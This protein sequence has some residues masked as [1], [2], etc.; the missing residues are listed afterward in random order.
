MVTIDPPPAA[1][2]SGS[3]ARAQATSE[4]AL[5]SSASQNRSRGVSVKRPSRSSAAA[6][7]TEWTSRSRCP[8][9]AFPTSAKTRSTSSSERT[10]H[11]VT[12]GLDTLPASSRTEGSIRSPWKVNASSAPSSA[13]LRAMP[14]AI[15]RLLATPKPRP[16][17]PSNLPTAR[18][19]NR[20]GYPSPLAPRDRFLRPRGGASRRGSDGSGPPADQALVR[21][22]DAAAP[23][24][25]HHPHPCRPRERPG[26]RDRDAEAAAARRRIR[27][28]NARLSVIHPAPRRPDGVLPRLPGARLHGATSRDGGAAPGDPGSEDWPPF[29]DRPR[30]ADGQ[31]PGEAPAGARQARLR[32]EGLPERPLHA[33]HRPAPRGHRRRRAA[34]GDGRARRRD[35]DRRG[36][37]R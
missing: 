17:L 15:E 14:H 13:S 21:R 30:R 9:N 36:R 16:R 37:R 11:A 2:I 29:S 4:Y 25:R 1:S 27:L 33:P 26:S 6:N 5:T 7:A 35:Q 3:A 34:R 20:V 8:S 31:H 10:S 24:R 32:R 18:E 19:S 23:S 22:G 28:A 12:S